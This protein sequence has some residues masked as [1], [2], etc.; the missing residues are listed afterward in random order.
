MNI[1]PEEISMRFHTNLPVES[2]PETTAFYEAFFDS[3]PVKQK[4]DYVKFLP[5][6]LALNLSFHQRKAGSTVDTF[7][8]IGF[9]VDTLE[10]LAAIRERLADRGLLPDARET[11]ICCYANQDKFHVVDPSGYTWEIY[12]LLEDSATR[13]S[14]STG[15]CASPTSCC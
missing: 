3:P 7:P 6:G 9:E 5:K 10:T 11:S 8:H 13:D 2:I 15:C 14:P 12:V 4:A 1:K